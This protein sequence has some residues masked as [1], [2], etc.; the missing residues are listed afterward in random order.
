MG[1]LDTIRNAPSNSLGGTG[2]YFADADTLHKGDEKYRIQGI[3]AAEV[4]KLFTG[5]DGYRVKEGTA[6]GGATTSVI[7]DL[8]NKQGFTNIVPLF[9]PDG[10]P[11]VDD[12]GRQ[13]A[14]LKDKSGNSFKSE[15]LN[16]GAFDVNKY[17]TNTDILAS[18]IARSQ[19][20][21]DAALGIEEPDAFDMAAEQIK[22]AEAAEGAKALGFKMTMLNEV[23]RQQYVDAGYGHM[24]TNQ[25]Q[26]AH[27]DRDINNNA[28]NPWS[29]S[30]EQGW[31]G[32][33]EA[34][35][36]VANMLGE[37]SDSEGLASWGQAGVDRQRAKFTEYGRTVLDYED[38]DGFW[39][40][41]E[42]LGNNL[43]L[44]LPYMGATALATVA[45]PVTGGASFSLPVSLYTGQVW[46]EMEGEKSASVALGAGIMQAALDRL[47]LKGIATGVPKQTFK[48]AAKKLADRDGISVKM[49]EKQLANATRREMAGLAKD[50]SAFAKQQ[51]E[52][53][54][55]FKQTSGQML[56]SGV[57]EG[58]TEMLQE[59]TAYTAAVQG[60]DKEW[61]WNELNNRVISAAIAGGTLGSAMSVPG[62]AWNAG[63]WADIAV[64]TAP[65]DA[66]RA[67]ATAR[68]QAEEI[69]TH[70][71]TMST[72]ELVADAGTRAK[73]APGVSINERAAADADRRK[74]MSFTD[75]VVDNL[76]NPQQFW[77]GSVR[78]IFTDS[79]KE[80]YR[81]A[82]VLG[83][84]LGGQLDKTF[85]GAGF[86]NGKHHNVAILKNMSVDPEEAFVALAGKRNVNRAE[87]EAVGDLIYSVVDKD[88]N[89]DLDKAPPA[90]RA[91]LQKILKENGAMADAAYN[92]Q[93]K[94]NP[95]LGY[96]DNYAM[97]YKSV[98]KREVYKD[99]EGFIETLVKEGYSRTEARELTDEIIENSEVNDIDEAFS[100]TKGGIVPPSH[101]KR[102]L[103]MAD[104]PA[105]AKFMERDFFAN[106]AQLAKSAAR[107][108]AHREFIGKDGEVISKLLDDLQAE[109]MPEAEVDAIAAKVQNIL[110]AES[111]NFKRPT[112]EA[113]KKWQK[114]QRNIMFYSTLSGLS[115][116][117]LSSLV[118]TMLI[119]KG[120]TADQIFGK[121]G[122][123]RQIGEE[124]ARTLNRGMQDVA[125]YVPGVEN[126]TRVNSRGRQTAKEL[127]HYEWDVGAATVTGVTETNA[128]SQKFYEKF[129]EI[130]GLTGYTNFTRA[131]RAGIGLD[132][133]NEKVS[134]LQSWRDSGEAK[135]NEIQE[136]EDHLRNLGVDL[137]EFPMIYMKSQAGLQLD[138]REQQI[139]DEN[140]REGVFNF[141]N[142]AI[143][144]P[145]AAN[146][147][148]IYQD[149]RFALFT[150]FQGFIATFTA[151]HIPKMWNEY[152]KRGTPAMKYNA[153]ALATT[154]IAMGFVSQYLKDLIKYGESSP[155]LDTSEY[156]QRG[157]RASGL[158][159]TS[160]RVL[161]WFFPIYEQRTNGVTDW[162]FSS[163][164]GES[165]AL[166]WLTRVGSAAG[167]GIEGDAYG[168]VYTGLRA[169]P[170][171]GPLTDFDKALAGLITAG[172]WNY[173]GGQ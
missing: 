11:M 109:G 25:V 88:G 43:A 110:D 13:L 29:D 94:Y 141:V 172:D 39:S 161:D 139:Y 107:F 86:E 66:A 28:L 169:T 5:S 78:N 32:V 130:T 82:R 37:V 159:G 98:N 116:A 20:D 6:G 119:S 47:G 166:S 61:D 26:V 8:A 160:E 150:Q 127:G 145:Q 85:S 170:F 123:L 157:V 99:Q 102:S 45:A 171:A 154:M 135:T 64:R 35:Y 80:S 126:K 114:V 2:A 124:A 53:K 52:A 132:Y 140:F 62:A 23:E 153:F 158:L 90:K 76:K 165:P 44:S 143:A 60:S 56:K 146:R 51:I 68:F 115:L 48:N 163:T 118:E 133:L 120:L 10:T 49:A 156:I 33:G 84:V 42:Y 7:S 128:V 113:G 112:S 152:V 50:A 41:V 54:N 151:N 40:G 104:N 142:D 30:W 122:S 9:N 69:A 38:V 18:Q 136:V 148:L 131:A 14:D 31:I 3:D 71:R 34:A 95:E 46:N 16:A 97:R 67:A 103:N 65:A 72:R 15:L 79:M 144:L 129:F 167:K 24:L 70:G 117:T 12:F 147:P 73:A 121:E 155:H 36:G 100:V 93:K 173:R 89:I 137:D 57:S 81:G 134:I 77:Q 92:M 75:K 17:T 83:D 106:Q 108:S 19:A 74:D 168:A 59:A 27:T 149:P 1:L 87:K 63:A 125:G 96:I 22:D 55:L 111:G 138:K 21:R 101:K 162:A 91:Y 105:F 4:T 58:A 164:V